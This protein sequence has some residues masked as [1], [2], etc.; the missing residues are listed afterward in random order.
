M[1]FN[2]IYDF[3]RALYKDPELISMWFWLIENIKVKYRVLNYD[4]YNFDKTRF[5]IGIICTIIVIIYIDQYDK[6]KAV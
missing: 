2:R 5:I 3:Q 6:G 4:F 1:Y